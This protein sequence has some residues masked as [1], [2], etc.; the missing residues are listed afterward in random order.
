MSFRPKLKYRIIAILFAI[1]PAFVVGSL[2]LGANMYYDLDAAKIVTNENNQ[3]VGDLTVSGNTTLATGSSTTN[4]FGTGTGAANTIGASGGTNAINGSTTILGTTLINSSGTA[5][6]TI[7]NGTGTLTL[8]GA[9]TLDNTFTISGNNLTSLG[10]NLSFTGA[11]PAISASTSGA[12]I[13][14]DANGTGSVNIAGTSTGDVNLAGGS[15]STGCTIT[16]STGAFTC[17]G[18]ITGPSAGTIGYWA[19]SGT[20]LSQATANDDLSLGSGS[21]TTTGTISSGLINSQTISSAANFTGTVTAATSFLAPTIDTATGIALNIG[22]A[23]QTALTIGRAGAATTINGSS[24]TIGPTAWTA[25][26]TISGAVTMTSGFDSNA[27]STAAGLTIDGNGNLAISSGTGT[28]SIAGYSGTGNAASIISSST[29][30][31]NKA[32]NISQTG[33]TTG[34]DYGLYV[35]NTGAGTTNVGG[36]FTASGATNNYGLIVA[37]GN[38]GIG[39]ATP[40]SALDVNGTV[41]MTGFQLGTSTTSGWVLTT[42]ASGVGTWQTVPSGLPSGTSG[43]TLRYNGS[44]TANSLLY[45]DGTNIGIGTVTPSSKLTLSAT[46]DFAIGDI[47]AHIIDS[48]ESVSGWT[49]YDVINTPV[50]LESTYVRDGSGSMKITTAAG[51]SNTDYVRKTFGA[52]QDYSTYGRIGFWIRATQTGQIISFRIN[53]AVGGTSAHNITIANANQ[54]QY[55]EYN[56]SSITPKNAISWVDFYINDDSL[57]PTFYIDQLRVYNFSE[58]SAEMFVDNDG[59]LVVL[60][61]GGVELGRGVPGSSLSSMKIG[62]ANVEIN[63]PMNVNVAGDTGIAYDL[64]FLNTG[65]SNITSQGPL[66]ISAGNPNKTQNLTLTTQANQTSGDSGVAT[67]GGASTLT[68]SSKSWTTNDW[69]NGTI[70]IISGTGAG[71][72]GTI[73]SNTG[74][75]I[76]VSSN[77]TT[78]PD[79]TS[80]YRLV[81]QQGGDVIIEVANASN[82]IGGFKVAGMDSGSYVFRVGPDGNV[83]IGGNGTAGSNLTVKQNLTLT[84]GNITIGKLA[85]SQAGTPSGTASTSGGSMS[86]ATYYYIVTALN[87]NGETTKSTESSGLT[88]ASGS[89]GSVVLSWTPVSGATGYKIYR[90]TSSGTYGATTL[91]S[92]VKAPIAT[93]TDTAASASTG[94]PPTSN[95]T[96]G[97]IAGILSFSDVGAALTVSSN[98][99]TVTQTYHS[100]DGT[101]GPQINIINGGA[102]GNILVLRNSGSAGNVTLHNYVSGT[103]NLKLGADCVL[104]NIDDNAVLIFNGTYWAKL[105][106]N[107]S[108]GDL[109]ENYYVK[110]LFVQP[111]DVVSISSQDTK[112][113]SNTDEGKYRYFVEKSQKSYDDG[114]MG[115][116]STDPHTVMGASG[117]ITKDNAGNEIENGPQTMPIALL[118]R[119]P[120]KV[121]LENGPINIGDPL[122]SSSVPG[123]AMSACGKSS[124]AGQAGSE[125]GKAYQCKSG[126]IIGRALEPFDGTV[127]N[128]TVEM[129]EQPAQ[130]DSSL[131]REDISPQS[132]ITEITNTAINSNKPKTL[133]VTKCTKEKADQAKV[134]TFVQPG[135]YEKDATA[136]DLNTQSGTSS[137][138]VLSNLASAVKSGMEEL[139]AIIENG[140]LKIKSIFVSDIT[141]NKLC[142]KGADGETICVEKDQLKD[143][144]NKNQILPAATPTSTLTITLTPTPTPFI[145][146]PIP[147]PTATFTP[148]PTATPISTTVPTPTPIPTP[149]PT[150]T[151]SPTPATTPTPVPSLEPTPIVTPIPTVSPTPVVTPTPEATSASTLEPSPMTTPMPNL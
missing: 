48:M 142:M 30:D 16:N 3:I 47:N 59:N 126:K 76:T 132:T 119:V 27:A 14:F 151:P 17:A 125:E 96:G 147:A 75:V 108:N 38:V 118:G 60:G 23:T 127:F 94:T 15:G 130:E 25:T 64:Q 46:S 116:I 41:K 6:T 13:S 58:R 89:T 37:S 26:P 98:T 20:T 12:S 51:N 104:H 149:I 79:T 120:V 55:E 135:L 53:D 19:R 139:G 134:M 121:S 101:G 71:Q 102:P 24:L 18:N 54:W 80:S 100:I 7:G 29:T 141:A 133:R 144:L 43:Q 52:N 95:T 123:V 138:G 36:Y 66:V 93:Y 107:N 9:T 103:D 5:S 145:P 78:Q 117:K 86:A 137:G 57:A 40:G 87:N 39:T 131:G 22:T 114:I 143:L 112:D 33:A 140:I 44:W 85:I 34:T 105:A 32:L 110:D 63:Q 82:N 136:I 122:T 67:A 69:T 50:T 113:F 74:T 111:G 8:Q 11:N 81:Y 92:T 129:V 28:F 49:P 146:S 150:M 70:Y 10:G 128:C 77:W 1:L 42:D 115:V 99:I 72:E 91:I 56:I 73:S 83:E 45:N 124:L 88:V 97:N 2:V 4:T 106:C 21:I 90:T 62:S 61:R 35:A 148:T 68:D 84:G 109:A 31:L 65:G